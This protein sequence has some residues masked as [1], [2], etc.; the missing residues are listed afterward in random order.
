MNAVDTNV[1]IYLHDPRDPRKQSQAIALVSA[2]RPG[3]LLWQVA[4][5]YVAVARKLRSIGVSEQ[6]IWNNLRELQK[7]WSTVTPDVQYLDR[8]QS[9]MQQRSLSFWDA[10][11]IGSAIES[12]ITTLYSE[13]FSG[14]GPIGGLQIVNPFGP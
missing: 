9:L 5:E 1:L 11:L 6:H 10:L 3:V 8:A 14:V 4:C 7:H 13:D 2:L 12:G